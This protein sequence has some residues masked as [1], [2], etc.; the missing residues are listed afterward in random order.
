MCNDYRLT[1]S[2]DDIEQAFEEAGIQLRTNA[3]NLQPR[4]NIRIGEN[5]PVVLPL[6]QPNQAILTPMRWGWRSSTGR[7]VFNVRSEGFPQQPKPTFLGASQGRCLIPANG[8]Y[9]FTAP[10]GE[11]AKTPKVKN[12]WLFTLSARALELLHKRYGGDDGGVFCI[13]GAWRAVKK[14]QLA[15][16]LETLPALDQTH[17]SATGVVKAF[18]MVTVEPGPDVKPYHKRQIALVGRGQWQNWL[19]GNLAPQQLRPLPAGTLD[20]TPVQNAN[21]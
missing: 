10:S 12:K 6:A 8:F 1:A 18:S 2:I 14:D 9:E 13:A 7:T 21:A 17:L 15:G 16:R 4:N 5:A 20:V 3:T 19:N 11:S